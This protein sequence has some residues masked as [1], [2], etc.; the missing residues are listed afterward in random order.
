ML[1]ILKLTLNKM[2]FDVMKTGEKKNEFRAPSKWI[3]SRLFNKDGS[4]K[5]YDFIEFSHGYKTDRNNFSCE[6]KGFKKTLIEKS[7]S[8]SN[9]L[10]I[11]VP[12]GYYNIFCGD[13]IFGPTETPKPKSKDPKAIDMNKVENIEISFTIDDKSYVLKPKK[14]VSKTSA[15]IY[16]ECA[17][18]LAF[19]SHEAFVIQEAD[20]ID[21]KNTLDE[22][23]SQ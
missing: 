2:P 10:E 14:D 6:F 11:T 4:K 22:I 1:K 12:R 19:D 18:M 16:L 13:I 17:L 8:Y 9:G 5:D 23:E 15:K 7:Y 3:E 21:L 20:M